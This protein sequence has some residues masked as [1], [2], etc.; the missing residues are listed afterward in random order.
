MLTEDEIDELE[1][2]IASVDGFSMEISILSKKSPNDGINKFKLNLVNSLIVK[3]NDFLDE[4]YRPLE[5]FES[6]DVDD[7]PTNSDVIFV[8]RQYDEALEKMRADNI[9]GY[10]GNFYYIAEDADLKIRAGDPRK[11]AKK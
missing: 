2:L 7:L 6:F 10:P 4:E 5:G 8:L 3:C 11:L 1:K 9:Q